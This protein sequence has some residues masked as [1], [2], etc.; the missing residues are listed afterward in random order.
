VYRAKGD[1]KIT[2]SAGGFIDYS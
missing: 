1:T 2:V